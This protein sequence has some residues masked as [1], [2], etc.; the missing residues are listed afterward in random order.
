MGKL[1]RSLGTV[2]NQLTS[3]VTKAVQDLK[4]GIPASDEIFL[5]QVELI[6]TYAAKVAQIRA[7]RDEILNGNEPLS[8][9]DALQHFLQHLGTLKAASDA[10]DPNEFPE[11]VLTFFKGA[12]RGGA[13]L[14]DFTPPVREWLA[15]QNLLKHVRVTIVN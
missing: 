14:D 7:E 13:R 9:A 10:L 11:D 12:R 4:G 1:K 3:V 5:K 8:S 2:S 6:P 15:E